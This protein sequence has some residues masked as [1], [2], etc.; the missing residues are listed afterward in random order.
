[1]A[2]LQIISVEDWT[3]LNK[4]NNNMKSGAQTLADKSFLSWVSLFMKQFTL[5]SPDISNHSYL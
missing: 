4:E 5:M 1:M 3:K 2:K